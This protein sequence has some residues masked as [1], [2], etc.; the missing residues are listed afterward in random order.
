MQLPPGYPNAN[1]TKACKL[2]KSLNGLK[3]ASRQWY[4]KLS[5]FI[6]EQGF[7]QLKVD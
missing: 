2:K 4:S 7:S 1:G 5:K 3:K 6:I